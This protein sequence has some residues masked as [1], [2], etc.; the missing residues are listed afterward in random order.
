VE[1]N[2]GKENKKAD[3]LTREED[4]DL[5]IE[6]E[7]ETPLLQAHG[8]GNLCAISFLSPTW[9][10]ELKASY[11][12]DASM[13]E[14]VGRFQDRE[15]SEGHYTFRSG[16]LL[17]KG[18]FFLSSESSMKPKAWHWFMTVHWGDI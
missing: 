11:E 9:L 10:E 2:Q 17:Y 15:D 3:G 8:Q 13:K 7:R 5:K 18:R 16:L 14:F 4:I 12:E 6:V 1:Y